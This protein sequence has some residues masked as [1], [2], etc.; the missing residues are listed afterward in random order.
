VRRIRVGFR[1]GI[2]T[3]E[4]CSVISGDMGRLEGCARSAPR[5]TVGHRGIEPAQTDDDPPIDPDP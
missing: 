2:S 1:P 3:V 4:G 5:G